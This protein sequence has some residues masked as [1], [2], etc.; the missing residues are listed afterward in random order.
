MMFDLALRW[1]YGL[2]FDLNIN[3]KAGID[4]FFSILFSGLIG[5]SGTVHQG[6]P[7]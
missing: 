7:Y 5:L 6:T 1:R 4:Q 2:S 3:R